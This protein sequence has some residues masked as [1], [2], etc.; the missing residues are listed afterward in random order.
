MLFELGALGEAFENYRHSLAIMERLTATD[1]EN[2][3]WQ[4][5]MSLSYL[6]MGHVLMELEEVDEALQ[7]YRQSLVINERLRAIDA[8]NTNIQLD[9][10]LL[11]KVI[12]EIL[13]KEGSH[14][15]ATRSYRNGLVIT[16]RLAIDDP[17]DVRNV[18]DMLDFQSRLATLADDSV[19]RLTLVVKGLRRLRSEIELTASQ[20]NW[21][22]K[23]ES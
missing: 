19:E 1:T 9:L 10:A 18:F 21:L 3:E 13:D 14:S 16:E 22:R 17:S 23:A 2:L 20:A 4:K 8:N 7:S 15:E 6:E 5:D 12:G 11:Y